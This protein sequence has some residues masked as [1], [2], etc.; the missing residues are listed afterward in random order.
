MRWAE[1]EIE[2]INITQVIHNKP[3][4]NDNTFFEE[5]PIWVVA[6]TN[7]LFVRAELGIETKW[8][9]KCIANGGVIDVLGQSYQVI[10]VPVTNPQTI[11]CVTQKYLDKYHWQL[12]VKLMVSR[13]AENSTLELIKNKKQRGNQNE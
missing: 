3:L 2:Q 8:Y 12:P 9:Q 10:Y 13:N 1:K 5:R 6:F 4:N 11:K 7:R